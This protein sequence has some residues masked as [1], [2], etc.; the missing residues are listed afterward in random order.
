[1]IEL[2]NIS[3]NYNKIQALNSINLKIKKGELLGLVGPNGAGKT[4]TLNI[5]SSYLLPTTGEIIFDGKVIQKFSNN[6]KMR[7]G[8][9]PQELSIY[10]KLTA[11]ENINFWGKIYNLNKNI[12]ESRREELLK[13]VGLDTRKNDLVSTFSGGMKRRL[14]IAI[15]LIHDPEFIF[16]DEPTVGVDPQ[17]RNFIFEMITKLHQ[18]GKTILYTSHYMEEVEKLCNRIVIIDKGEIVM[19]GSKEEILNI[20]GNKM[21]LEILMENEI[22]QLDKIDENDE[23]KIDEKLIQISGKKL[24]LRL[25]KYLQAIENENNKILNLVLH[26]VT[27]EEIFLK[28]TGKEMRE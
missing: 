20:Y 12:L 2:S 18:A 9:I 22:Q 6:E 13:I 21:K 19:E 7:I 27:L 28:L 23:I 1:M 4:T 24:S 3:K 15:G 17:S 5:L 25:S 11:S 16:L 26:K 14:N 10:E 8:Y